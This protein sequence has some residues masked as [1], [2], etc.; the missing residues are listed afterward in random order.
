MALH[1]DKPRWRPTTI[2][3][4]SS[5]SH[6]QADSHFHYVER[7]L[8]ERQR[9]LRG[10]LNAALTTALCASTPGQ[11]QNVRQVNCQE[12]EPKADIAAYIALGGTA[13]WTVIIWQD[14]VLRESV[15]TAEA[16]K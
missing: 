16:K 10:D 11:S 12:G 15:L 3:A 4:A 9:A 14:G 8:S 5:S 2:L 6:M 7:Q 1:R 13:I